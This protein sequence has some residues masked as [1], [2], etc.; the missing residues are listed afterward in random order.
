MTLDKDNRRKHPEQNRTQRIVMWSVF[1][2]A[3]VLFVIAAVL[4]VISGARLF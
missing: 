2:V 3:G 1:G 4:F